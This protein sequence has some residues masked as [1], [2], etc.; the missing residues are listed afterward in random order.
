MPSLLVP[1][2][3]AAGLGSGSYEVELDLEPF[4]GGGLLLDLRVQKDV[5]GAG[6]EEELEAEAT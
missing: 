3:A 6:W 2:P 4:R 5:E 1:E